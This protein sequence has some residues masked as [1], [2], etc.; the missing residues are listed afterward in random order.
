MADYP[1]P[2]ATPSYIPMFED[3]DEKKLKE[4][5]KKQEEEEGPTP[6]QIMDFTKNQ[7]MPTSNPLKDL[8]LAQLKKSREAS[9]SLGISSSQI[10]AL[11]D[12]YSTDVPDSLQTDVANAGGVRPLPPSSY[13]NQARDRMALLNPE[14]R[15]IAFNESSGG[16][17]IAHKPVTYGLNKGDTAAGAT[18]MMPK[19]ALDAIENNKE[20]MEKYGNLLE[21]S[22]KK[23][24][25]FLNE[26]PDA[27]ADI[28]NAHWQTIQK[29]IP[30]D[31]ERQAYAWRW[32]IT[33]AKRAD[34]E[35]IANEPYVQK[36]MKKKSEMATPSEGR[37]ANISRKLKNN[38]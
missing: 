28:S 12:L 3:E 24:T 1:Y 6:K 26:N 16:K 9:G 4:L 13:P 25:K 32:G 10:A 15:A 14:V 17:N 35:D 11:K 21:T 31:P 34:E 27:V 23:V 29:A 33:G 8:A 18:G 37:F 2:K 36:F 20:L 5:K 22:P 38:K 19:T 30:D 7:F